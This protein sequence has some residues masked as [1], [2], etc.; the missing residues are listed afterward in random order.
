MN[1]GRAVLNSGSWKKIWTNYP[2][3]IYTVKIFYHDVTFSRFAVGR[4]TLPKLG[5]KLT[6]SWKSSLKGPDLQQSMI[7]GQFTKNGTFINILAILRPIWPQLCMLNKSASHL[8]TSFL[9]LVISSTESFTPRINLQGISSW[10]NIH[11]F[12]SYTKTAVYWVELLINSIQC[13]V[14]DNKNEKTRS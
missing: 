6:I 9:V 11:T 5:L 8:R 2:N 3:W 14:L 12:K 13:K 4:N 10:F 1:L 7:K